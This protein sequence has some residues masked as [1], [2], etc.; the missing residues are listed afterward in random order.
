MVRDSVNRPDRTEKSGF[1]TA[2]S[3]VYSQE[4][5]GEFSKD[6]PVCPINQDKHSSC[7]IVSSSSKIR[8]EVS[9]FVAVKSLLIE[10]ATVDASVAGSGVTDSSYLKNAS[11]SSYRGIGESECSLSFKDDFGDSKD[12][13]P[14]V[15]PKPF[16]FSTPTEVDISRSN[17]GCRIYPD[18][19]SSFKNFFQS[20]SKSKVSSSS[21]FD[22]HGSISIESGSS[23][24][25]TVSKSASVS[26]ISRGN[27]VSSSTPIKPSGNS[28]FS[29]NGGHAPKSSDQRVAG[30]LRPSKS[31]KACIPEI[32]VSLIKQ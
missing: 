3:T 7:D 32:S 17:S 5:S 31:Y 10:N 8:E 22:V 29:S 9:G 1:I 11:F 19:S 28:S 6:A 4:K 15:D 30:K 26:C 14:L 18:K 12:V 13:A 21:Y 25:S 23:I 16:S 27:I 24:N 2:L 20:E